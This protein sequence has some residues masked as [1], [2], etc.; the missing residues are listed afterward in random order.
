MSIMN[1][2]SSVLGGGS[3][4][5]SGGGGLMSMFSGGGGGGED[6]QQP[7]GIPGYQVAQA[8]QADTSMFTQ[9]QDQPPPSL[10]FKDMLALRINNRMQQGGGQQA[11]APALAPPVQA[12]QAPQPNI[13]MF[14]RQQPWQRPQLQNLGMGRL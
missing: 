12:V 3:K 2:L 9:G 6:Q 1:I 11:Q 7:Q 13:S 14:T 5:V 10:N 4:G 8:P